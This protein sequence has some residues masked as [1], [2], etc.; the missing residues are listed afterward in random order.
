[1]DRY[2]FYGFIRNSLYNRSASERVV[3]RVARSHHRLYTLFTR[4]AAAII[5]HEILNTR[6]ARGHG[7][8]LPLISNGIHSKRFPFFFFVSFAL[9]ALHGVRRLFVQLYTSSSSCVRAHTPTVV[10]C[11]FYSMRSPRFSRD[12]CRISA[13]VYRRL[14]SRCAW[15]NM[16]EYDGRRTKKGR[17][18]KIEIQ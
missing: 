4:F 5:R 10:E 18:K 14:S 6:C 2:Y 13:V 11:F 8:C 16:C 12:D 9:P 3:S 7:L 15:N 17:T 1:M